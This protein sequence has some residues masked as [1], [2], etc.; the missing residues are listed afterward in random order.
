MNWTALLRLLRPH[1]WSKNLLCLLPL[2]LSGRWHD[3]ECVLGSLSAMAA[4]S[5]LASFIY[6]MNDL[7]DVRADRA[8]P[9]KRF[10]PLAS[11][12]VS[13]ST[14][15]VTAAVLVCLTALVACWQPEK[16]RWWL[17]CY[18]VTALAYSWRLKTYLVMD[19]VALASF[20]GLRVLYGGAA[21]AIPV[22]VWTMV[23]CLFLFSTLALVKRYAEVAAQED[24]PPADHSALRRP[25]RVQDRTVLLGLACAGTNTSLLVVALYL[26]SPEVRAIHQHPQWLWLVLPALM[27]WMARILVIVHR[28]EMHHDPLVF[29]LRDRGSWA[30]LVWIVTVLVASK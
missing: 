13:L 28:G 19:V 2:L 3:K 11:G 5:L 25:Y 22:S 12:E 8:H 21:A 23:F 26:N 1:Q 30:V 24:D 29:A 10:R 17:A 16:A 6:V 9:K 14:A 20:Y 4:F 18:T 15:M 27:Y 7:M